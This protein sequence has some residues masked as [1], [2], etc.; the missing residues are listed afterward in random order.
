MTECLSGEVA[1]AIE[2]A[3]SYL[4]KC[5]DL[6][7]FGARIFSMSCSDETHP[8][9]RAVLSEGAANT[10]KKIEFFSKMLSGLRSIIKVREC[11]DRVTHFQS[12]LLEKV[13]CSLVH[14]QME[15]E[16]DWFSENFDI[17]KASE[18]KYFLMII[19]FNI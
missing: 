2:G 11:F 6:E 1:L 17:K 12:P 4:S 13:V 5:G 14:E 19:S 9:A 10:K 18:G 16:L 3:R 8:N 15:P 7:R